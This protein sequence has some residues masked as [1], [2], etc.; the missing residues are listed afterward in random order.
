MLTVD[1][2]CGV[3]EPCGAIAGV[4][5]SQSGLLRFGWLIL[6]FSFVTKLFED[7]RTF[8]IVYSRITV[9]TGANGG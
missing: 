6:D 1:V 4:W 7:V 2:P 5:A 3:W 9:R 8:G